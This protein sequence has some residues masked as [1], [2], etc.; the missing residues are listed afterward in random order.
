MEA[1][2]V[3][4]PIAHAVFLVVSV[5]ILT[6]ASAIAAEPTIITVVM[7]DYKF[8]PDHLVFQHGTRYRLHLE[9]VGKELHEFTAA[10]FFKSAT[11]ENPEVL[12][13]DHTDVVLQ[14]H[15]SKDVV[16]VPRRQGS[17]GLVCADHDWDGMIGNIT[18]K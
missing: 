18:V 12:N 1:N 15:E 16:L 13:A 2:K 14:P 7:T 4:R 6:D 10:D 8:N 9:N 17:Y 5:A 3:M 11:I